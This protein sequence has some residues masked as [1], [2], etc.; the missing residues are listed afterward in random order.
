[1]TINAENQFVSGSPA[2]PIT[3]VYFDEGTSDAS[4]SGFTL[5][6]SSGSGANIAGGNITIAPGEGTGT[7][8]GGSFIVQTSPAGSSGSAANALVTRMTID[9]DGNVT[10]PAQ[11]C[12][13][14]FN[15]VTDTN[16]TGNGTAATVD[17]DTEVFDQG[18]DFATDTF[19][20]PVTGRYLLTANVQL[21]GLTTAA[22]SSS[23]SII[24][25]NRTY[26]GN[27]FDL[28]SGY[29]DILGYTITVVADMDSADTATVSVTVA[30]EASDVVDVEGDGT[31]LVT[32]FSG[33]LVS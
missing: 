28:V 1:M 30:G 10:T 11:P 33:C 6:A 24:T 23:V 32:S 18:A 15:S 2:R 3:D 19:T 29:P 5:H 21:L 16:V 12:F 26:R 25:S 8:V 13:L 9:E 14:A 27:R 22:D 31:I 17:F 7:G 4:P 20:A